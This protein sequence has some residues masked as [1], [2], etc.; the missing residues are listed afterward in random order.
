MAVDKNNILYIKRDDAS[1]G[2]YGRLSQ[3]GWSDEQRVFT[4]AK[5]WRRIKE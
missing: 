4:K 3:L 5:A 1:T 2:W